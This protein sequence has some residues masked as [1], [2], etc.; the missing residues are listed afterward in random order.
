MLTLF[1]SATGG[2][3]WAKFY[4]VVVKTGGLNTTVFIV[5][6]AFFQIA[7]LNILTGIFVDNAVKFAKPD[8]DASALQHRIQ[9]ILEVQ[10]L[11]EMCIAMD[12]EGRGTVAREEFSKQIAGGQLRPYLA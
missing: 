3:D 6:I 7:V 12:G 10:Q 9:E 2:D 11:R 8:N 5:F 4:D 1:M